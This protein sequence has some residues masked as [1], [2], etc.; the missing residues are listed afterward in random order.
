MHKYCLKIFILRKS[1]ERDLFLH[2][3]PIFHDKYV[4]LWQQIGLTVV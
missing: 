1:R 4:F 3:V 2:L